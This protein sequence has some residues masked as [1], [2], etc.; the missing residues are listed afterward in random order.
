MEEPSGSRTSVPPLLPQIA[1]HPGIMA[2][3][4]TD[5][6]AAAVKKLAPGELI[7]DGHF[8]LFESVSALEIMDPKMDSGCLSEGESLDEEYDVTKNLLPEE[9][10]GIIDQLLCLEMAWHLGYPLSQTLFTS[11]HLETLMQPIPMCLDDANFDRESEEWK[12]KSP[13]LFVLRAYG[14]ALLKGCYYVNELVK[15]ELY[16]E[17]EDFVTNTYDRDLLTNVS[18]DDINELLR[19]TRSE[20]RSMSNRLSKEVREALDLRLEFRI[21]F[22]RAMELVGIARAN[23]ES[24][25][26]PWIMMSGVLEH[27]RKQHS[28]GTPVPEAFSTKMQRRLAST[29]PPRPIVQLTFEDTCDHFKRMAQDGKEAMNILIYSDPQSLMTFVSSFQARRPQPL[30]IIRTLMQG[31]MFKEMIVLG[32]YSIRHI[33]DHDLSI[34]CLPNAPQTDPLNDTVEVVTHPRHQ[35]AAQMEVFRQRVADCYLDLYRIFCQNRC[36][37]RRTLC[38]SIQEWDLLQADVE[39]ID[40]LLQ[41]VLDEQ[42]YT[43]QNGPV[44]YSLPLSSWAYLYKLRQMEWIVQLGFELSV[45]QVDELAGMY[46]YLNYVAKTRA[47]HGDRIKNFV[48]KSMFEARNA[49]KTY[50][51]AKEEKYMKSMSYIRVTMLDAAC[52]WE[53]ADGLCCLYTVLQRLKLIKPPPRPYSDDLLRYEIRMKPFV[54]IGLPQLPSFDDFTKATQQPETSIPD[55]LKYADGA[56]GGAKKGYEALSRMQEQNTFSVGCH[57]R[58]LANVKNCQKAT[59]FAGLA[60]TMLQKAIEKSGEGLDGE[61]MGLKVEMPEEGKGYHD[62]WIVPKIVSTAPDA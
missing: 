44:G 39:E 56:V 61:Q 21:A 32:S 30:V 53:F 31:L 60:V 20:L 17:E 41:H 2:I 18:L 62:W 24:L 38:H 3:D 1:S 14:I 37:V 57:E 9:I 35:T 59:I 11:V 7:K 45:Y 36:R 47:Q 16:Y 42:P 33:L 27:L 6:F 22:L 12:T 48:M 40:N 43:A 15:D 34:V 49:T 52:T 54:N 10:L 58:W 51:A 25:K 28:L 13:F 23:P 4:I 50:S 29:M 46:W 5:K 26:T 55:L 8:T 19:N